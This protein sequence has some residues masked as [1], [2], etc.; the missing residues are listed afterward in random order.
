MK[1][2]EEYRKVT[3]RL[4]EGDRER[5]EQYFPHIGYNAAIRQLVS[6]A[7]RLLDEKTTRGMGE[8]MEV[9]LDLKD[10]ELE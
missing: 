7:L 4:F 9:H 6:K 1:A 2:R 8:S 3:I 10:E 5:L